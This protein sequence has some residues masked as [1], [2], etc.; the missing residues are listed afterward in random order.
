MHLSSCGVVV[1]RACLACI[2]GLACACPVGRMCLACVRPLDPCP[3][4]THKIPCCIHDVNPIAKLFFSPAAYYEIATL[5]LCHQISPYS[6]INPRHPSPR[7]T[8]EQISTARKRSQKSLREAQRAEARREKLQYRREQ[9]KQARPHAR[10]RASAASSTDSEHGHT[11]TRG[12][13]A[14]R[15]HTHTESGQARQAPRGRR[16]KK[17]TVDQA[18]AGAHTGKHSEHT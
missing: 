9:R 12:H 6:N 1:G 15:A 18:S 3:W 4:D 8:A 14:A 17:S 5:S 13:T 10:A 16:T 7:T 2:G 11:A